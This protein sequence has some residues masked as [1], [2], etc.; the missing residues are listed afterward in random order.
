MA[1][2]LKGLLTKA[3]LVAVALACTNRT[4]ISCGNSQMSGIGGEQ[5]LG[6]LSYGC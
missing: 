5:R 1:L 2:K 3:S 6:K 4:D